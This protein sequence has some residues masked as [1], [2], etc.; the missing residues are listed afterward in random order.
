MFREGLYLLV[1]INAVLCSHNFLD[2]DMDLA[3]GV[4]L[5]SVP[6]SNSLQDESGRSFGENSPLFR[7]AKFL[8]GH[9]LHVKLPNLIEKDKISQIFSESLKAVDETYKENSVSGRGNKGGGGGIL[10]LGMMFAKTLAAAGI[11]GLALLTMK[12]DEKDNDVVPRRWSCIWASSKS[13]LRMVIWDSHAGR[14]RR[15]TKYPQWYQGISEKP[16]HSRAWSGY[17]PN[18]A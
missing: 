15:K 8:Q 9:E 16:D 2:G 5:V 3:E 13:N 14:R 7:M 12:A 17:V 4:K 11:G 18:L 1:L 10:L 6:V